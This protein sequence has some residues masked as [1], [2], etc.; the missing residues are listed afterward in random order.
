MV[1]VVHVKLAN[2]AV[3]LAGVVIRQGVGTDSV[4]SCDSITIIGIVSAITVNIND[5]L[6]TV[7]QIPQHLC[8]NVV[9]SDSSSDEKTIR[10][11]SKGKGIGLLFLRCD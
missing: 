10:T 2:C 6:V 8:R 5:Y 4:D 9:V 7:E 1:Q 3:S 11:L